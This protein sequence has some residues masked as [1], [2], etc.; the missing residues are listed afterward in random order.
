VRTEPLTPLS[1]LPPCRDRSHVHESF[2]EPPRPP[3]APSRE[4]ENPDRD[5]GCLP[6]GENLCPAT[7]FRTPGSGLSR[8]RSLAA[9]VPVVDA[10][11]TRVSFLAEIFVSLVPVHA[12]V[13]QRDRV[14]LNL[15]VVRRLLQPMSTRGHTLSSCLSSHASAAFTPLLAGTNRC[16]LRWPFRRVAA[17]GAGEPRSAHPG[18]RTVCSTCVDEAVCAGRGA[19]EK[20][21]ARAL[22]EVARA[23]LVTPRAPG[24]PAR[25][26]PGS[27]K[28][29][30]SSHRPRPFL[31]AAS[32]KATPSRGSRC[33]LPRR[34][35]YAS[36]GLLLRARLDRAPV[37]RPPW[38]LCSGGRTPFVARSRRPPLTRTALRAGPTR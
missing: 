6:S 14:S 13:C 32:R 24:S 30:D 36:G 16:Q 38:R 4:R 11:V 37:T 21:F 8:L 18:F 17:W 23:L 7:S 33:L 22:D 34:N 31:D 26:V 3:R 2:R 10:L 15:G 28:P 1:P 9:A 35:P 27:G 12:P 20:V 19:R 25:F 29:G 5:P